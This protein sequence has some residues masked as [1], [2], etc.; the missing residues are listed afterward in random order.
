MSFDRDLISSGF[1]AVI[2]IDLNLRVV[3]WN[4][5]TV[6]IFGIEEIEAVG[7]NVLDLIGSHNTIGKDLD[8]FTNLVGGSPIPRTPGF[9]RIRSG[10]WIN[11][12]MVGF[13][14]R[15]E[16]GDLYGGTVVIRDTS[17]QL[18]A[19]KMLNKI[20]EVG[21][22]IGF[23]YV[24]QEDS[25]QFSKWAVTHF[26]MPLSEKMRLAEFKSLFEIEDRAVIDYI[27]DPGQR[28]IHTEQR[29][30]KWATENRAGTLKIGW[31]TEVIGIEVERIFGV[32]VDL[33]EKVDQEA[34]IKQQE[35]Q[36][37]TR[38]RL[39]ALG[40]MA[41]GVAHEI[42]NPLAIIGSNLHVHKKRMDKGGVTQEQTI[43]FLDGVDRSVQRISKIVQGLMQFSTQET[44]GSLLPV[45]I[46]ELMEQVVGFCELKIT[47]NNIRIDM[48]KV[49]RNLSV[50]GHSTELGQVFF[51]IVSNAADYLSHQNLAEREIVIETRSEADG[52]ISVLISNN[53]EKISEELVDQIFQPFF[54]TKEVGEGT[55]L[56]LSI[57]YSIIKHHGGNLFVDP[58][59]R[60]TTFVAT[61]PPATASRKRA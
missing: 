49:D 56:G 22:N 55:G 5:Q 39:K 16:H 34:L 3:C 13:P 25:L 57:C 52:W 47:R 18:K 53:G 33:T 51:N 50:D 61:F 28:L 26:K 46:G 38:N 54:T 31:R 21:G 27:F 7:Q 35:Q 19:E 24:F 59:S 11:T 2:G 10:A 42:N 30:V 36:I 6:A 37:I 14:N 43:K 48:D 20:E 45:N 44:D 40:E 58:N 29:V 17:Q 32:L 12:E 4:E 60:W 1:D 8:Y 23:E 9:R 41:A 15:D